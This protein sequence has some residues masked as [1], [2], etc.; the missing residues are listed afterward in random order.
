MPEPRI[1]EIS[2]LVVGYEK[3]PI[4]NGVSVYVDPGEI[5]AVIGHNGAGKSTLLKCVFGLLPAWQG[6]IELFGVA[7]RGVRSPQLLRRGVSYSPQGNR[8]FSDL[9]VEENLQIAGSAVD[10]DHWEEGYSRVCALFP[11]LERKLG[12]RAGTLSGGEKQ[13][14]ALGCVLILQPRLLLLDEPSLGLSPNLV[15]SALSTIC[16]VRTNWRAAVVIVEQ[17]VREVLKVAD[18]AYVFRNGKISYSG[19]STSLEDENTLRSAFF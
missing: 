12:Q 10:R 6:E 15:R 11:V 2:N 4:L 19:P 8:V 9:T 18:R 5:V 1:L 3:K 7:L 13:M 17:K 16:E 14:L